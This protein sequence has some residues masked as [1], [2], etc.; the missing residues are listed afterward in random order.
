ADLSNDYPYENGQLSKSDTAGTPYFVGFDVGDDGSITTS[1]G[2]ILGVP[3]RVYPGKSSHDVMT[4]KCA[5]I[6]ISN[7]TYEA[8]LHRLQEKDGVEDMPH[9]GPTDANPAD[10]PGKVQVQS[11]NFLN[12]IGDVNLTKGTGSISYVISVS[13]ATVRPATTD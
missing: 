4:K 9:P 12:V 1:S 10:S 2:T 8:I 5:N 11:G 13:R 7:Y 6:W 3:P